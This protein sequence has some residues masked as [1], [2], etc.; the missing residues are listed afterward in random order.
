MIGRLDIAGGWMWSA[1]QPDRGLAFNSY[2]FERDGGSVAI[3]PLALD[4]ASIE[5]LNSAGGVATIVLT[6]RDHQR[7][8]QALRQRFGARVLAHALEAERFSI[9]IDATFADGEEVFPGVY[10]VALPYGKTPG[11]VA[12]HLRSARAAI[13]GDALIGAPAGALSLLPDGKLED[14]QRLLRSLRKLW[15]LQLDALLLCDGA[16]IFRN[17]DAVLGALLETRGGA[18][19]NRINADEIAFEHD[20][21]HPRYESDDGEVGLLIGSRQLG[22]RLTRVAPGKAFCP[23]HSHVAGEEFFYVIEGAPSIRTLRGTVRC[24]PGDFIAFP[25]GER[26][27]HQLLND[28]DAPCLLLL[29]GV[30]EGKEVCFYPDS[31]KVLVDVPAE[32]VSVMVRSAPL[33]DYF[34][35]E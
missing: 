35:G 20:A 18:E 14:P 10:A 8:A 16:P 29:V 23:L 24:R 6:N 11:E 1:W 4:D 22:Y 28:S 3:D 27:T 7:E 9:P 13:V 30:E 19:I 17:A 33:L 26:G 2:L 34:D 5:W 25:T 31:Q 21:P 32:D 15:A 12:L